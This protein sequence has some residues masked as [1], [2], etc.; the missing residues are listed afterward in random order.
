MKPGYLTVYLSL[1]LAIMMSLILSIIEGARYSAMRL[2]VETV[3]DMGIDSVFSEYNRE[4]L[5]QYDLFFI[6]TSYGAAQGSVANTG[7]HLAEYMSY[8]F[9]PKKDESLSFFYKDFMNVNIMNTEMQEAAFATDDD[10]DVFKRQAIEYMQDKY[11][12]SYFE[13]LK[14]QMN[15]VT[16]EGWD[17]G[18]IMDDL[19][20]AVGE[21]EEAREDIEETGDDSLLEEYTDVITEIHSNGILNYVVPNIS[22][23]SNQSVNLSNYASN[24][25]LNRGCGL[26]ED[27]ETPDGLMDELIFG[28]YIMEKYGCFT[29]LK[30]DS[31]LKYQI[32]YILMGKNN[33]TENLK[34]FVNTLFNLRALANLAY[35]YT[36]SVKQTEVDAIAVLIATAIL[37]PELEEVFALIINIV[38][39]YVE[40]IVDMRTLLSGGKVPLWKSSSSWCLS[41]TGLGNFTFRKGNSEEGLSY[42]DYLR[43]FVGLMN[44]KTKVFHSMD[45]AEM[46]IRQT[47][48]NQ[49]FKLDECIDYLNVDIALSSGYGYNFLVHKRYRYE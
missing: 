44:K 4:L 43:I 6:D 25:N 14:D 32:E 33:D 46:D 1:T 13:V 29:E 30:D 9:N 15:T 49:Y 17:S 36:D 7:D 20:H 8:N 38:W 24:R 12:V 18:D 26:K 42:K 37:L 45:I 2:Q 39:A 10:G 22:G 34:A 35:L 11:M 23:I 48:G 40:A 47:L 28:E 5:N 31:L 27:V 19:Q 3:T 41:L 16:S 21:V